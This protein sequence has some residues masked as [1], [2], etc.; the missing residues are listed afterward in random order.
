MWTF[1]QDSIMVAA[2]VA[3]VNGFLIWIVKRYI[4]S[5][6]NT[7]LENYRFELKTREQA[8]KIAEYASRAFFLKST[9]NDEAYQRAN[10]LSWELF[11]LLPTDVYR[12]LGRG[13]REKQNVGELVE[14]LLDVRKVLLGKTSAGDLN[15]NDFIIHS[16]N[17][18]RVSESDQVTAEPSGAMR[19]R[20][21]LGE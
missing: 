16:P 10:Q 19:A 5:R 13:L 9:D 3:A 6:F 2:I 12:K 17:I 20:R 15:G 14:S 11:L 7:A 21:G 18:G 1:I 8:A 4:D